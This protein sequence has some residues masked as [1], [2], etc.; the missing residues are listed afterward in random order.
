MH[1]DMKRYMKRPIIG[2]VI[3]LNQYLMTVRTLP[4]KDIRNVYVATLLKSADSLFS[5][6]LREVRGKDYLKRAIETVDEIVGRTYLIYSLHGWSNKVTARI[7]A[8]CEEIAS[9]LKKEDAI[10][11]SQNH[12][13]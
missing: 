4:S 8:M 5:Q 13:A 2:K 3:A 11:K 6:A 10:I 9:E 1:Q 12:E 7:D